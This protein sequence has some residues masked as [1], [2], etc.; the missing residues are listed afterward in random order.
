MIASNADEPLTARLDP[1]YIDINGQSDFETWASSGN[2]MA[3]TP[4]IIENRYVNLSGQSKGG[5]KIFGT[6]YYFIIRNCIFIGDGFYSGVEI[7]EA[8][9]GAVINST[10]TNFRYGISVKGASNINITRNN[11]SRNNWRGLELAYVLGPSQFIRVINNTMADQELQ[12]GCRVEWV[13]NCIFINNTFNN[14][15]AK[16]LSL[17]NAHYNTIENNSAN[18]NGDFGFLVEKSYFNNFTR[19]TA[20]GNPLDGIRVSDSFNNTFYQNTVKGNDEYGFELDNTSYCTFTNNTVM[21]NG[22]RGIL[23]VYHSSHNTFSLNIFAGNGGECIYIAPTCEYNEIKDNT[24]D[25]I[26]NGEVAGFEF[27]LSFLSLGA[28]FIY[29]F[30]DRSKYIKK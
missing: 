27:L 18:N 1:Y 3:G 30:F 12:C 4:Y 23:L 19:N 22:D 21:D 14:N 2:G 8:Q 15:G 26:E 10:F 9:N 13:S 28:I 25:Y 6:G 17:T 11:L 5:I 7:W 29:S 24:C 20:C 16:G